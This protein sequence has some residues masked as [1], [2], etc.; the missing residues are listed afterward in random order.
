MSLT[1]W[2]LGAFLW[3]LLDK[4]GEN[5]PFLVGGFENQGGQHLPPNAFSAFTR[6][7]EFNVYHDIAI[8]HDPFHQMTQLWILCYAH[9]TLSPQNKC[10]T[11][12]DGP[13]YLCLA[14]YGRS[15]SYIDTTGTPLSEIEFA[16]TTRVSGS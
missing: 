6:D 5:G 14:V 10:R 15:G 13:Y 2:D 3:A 12:I 16:S 8:K 1:G 9:I 7:L 11:L 4:I